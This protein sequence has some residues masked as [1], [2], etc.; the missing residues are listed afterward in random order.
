MPRIT[1]EELERQLT[2]RR[3]KPRSHVENT[4]LSPSVADDP[5]VLVYNIRTDKFRT[6]YQSSLLTH[7]LKDAPLIEVPGDMPPLLV[8]GK[9]QIIEI[10]KWR[11]KV[12]FLWQTNNGVRRKRKKRVATLPR[13]IWVDRNFRGKWTELWIERGA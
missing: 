10:P 8:D 5:I 12:D 9:M 1:K 6:A 13:W 7:D 3:L 11:F 2:N 4:D